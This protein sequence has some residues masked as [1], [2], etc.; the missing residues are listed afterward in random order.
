MSQGLT[1]LGPKLGPINWQFAASKKFDSEDVGAFLSLLPTKKY[2]IALRHALEVR[3]SS[4]A[5]QACY[6]LARRHGV[7]IVYA[8]DEDFPE[9]DQPTAS[10]TY[11]RLMSTDEELEL[12]V[13]G[14]ALT[15]L[16]KRLKAWARHG[17]VFAYFIAGAKKRNPAAAQALIEKLG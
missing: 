13:S 1:E 6:D 7:A 16:A 9:I 17:D 14:H 15:G 12:G 11:A 4:F 3:H 8:A 10:F 5:T 2:G